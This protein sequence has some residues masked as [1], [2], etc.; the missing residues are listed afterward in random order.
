[1]MSG[2][3]ARLGWLVLASAMGGCVLGPD[4]SDPSLPPTAEAP[5]QLV[6]AY[7]LVEDGR[8]QLAIGR[9]DAA[10]ATFQKALALAPSSP[11]ANLA[12]GEAKLRQGEAR[13]A[14]IYCDRV[15][16]LTGND[17][18]WRLRV[19][20]LRGRAYEAAGDLTRA[21]A[22]YEEA[23]AIDPRD[24]EAREGVARLDALPGGAR[25]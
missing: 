8:Q 9:T 6:A 7:H 18:L 14:L 22:A 11:H 3:S 1:M 2:W 19:A 12:L 13:S 20:G 10:L 5:P 24:A 21:R 16:R 23:L 25:P 17:P 4:P 15:A